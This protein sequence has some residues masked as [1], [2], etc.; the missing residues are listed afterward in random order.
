MGED[1]PL[2]TAADAATDEVLEQL[3][4][5]PADV[6][7]LALRRLRAELA[8]L[9]W[10]SAR[11]LHEQGWDWAD[12]GRLLGVSRQAARERFAIRPPAGR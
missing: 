9:Q 4:D 6:R 12:V 5:L 10:R 2:G 7:L 1:A 8:V 3:N 11:E